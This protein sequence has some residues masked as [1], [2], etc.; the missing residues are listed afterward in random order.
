MNFL[1]LVNKFRNC[2]AFNTKELRETSLVTMNILINDN[3]IIKY[4][5]YRV[6]YQQLEEL[7]VIIEDLKEAGVI[8]DSIS[9]YASPAILVR[10]KNGSLR[11]CIDYRKLNKITRRECF[12]TPNIEEQLNAMVGGSMFCSLDMM[13]GYYQVGIESKCRHLTAF[14]TPG[15]HFQFRRMPFGLTNAPSVFMRLM[16][17]ILQRLNDRRVF[18]Y[19]DDI[20]IVTETASEALEVL[21]KLFTELQQ[22][23]LSLNIQKCSFFVDTV[24]YLGHRIGK[25]GIKPGEQK[26]EAIKHYPEPKNIKEVRQFLGLTGY[27]RRF[28]PSYANI[29]SPLNHLLKKDVNFQW[30]K[31]EKHA[32]EELKHQ[33]VKEPVLTIYD[34]TKDHEVHTDAC[35]TGLAGTLL[36]NSDG[37]QKAVA[38]FSRTTTEQERKYHSYELEALAVVESLERFRYYLLGKKFRIVTDCNSLKLTQEKQNIIPRIARWWL[39]IQEFDF[40]I[41]YRSAAKIVHVDALSRATT[42]EQSPVE[43]V[44]EKVMLVDMEESDWVAVLQLQDADL[45]AIRE[46]LNGTVVNH[47]KVKHYN[48]EYQVKN[49][50]VFKKTEQGLRFVVPHGVRWQIIKTAHNESGHPG[51]DRTIELIRKTYWFPQMRAIIRKYI[52]SCLDCLHNKR[53]KDESRREMFVRDIQPIPFHTIHMDHLGPYPK[54]TA[55]NM[56]LIGVIDAFTKFI[57]LKAV[58]NTRSQYVIRTLE[59]ISQY[60]GLPEQVIT[61]RGT[62]YTSEAFQEFCRENDVVHIKNAVRTPRGNGQIERYFRTVKTAISSMVTRKDGKDWDKSLLAIQW[63]LNNL[64]HRITKVS[65]QKLLLGFE[66][67]SI[68]K[69]KLTF[70]LQHDVSDDEDD[71]P[72]SE[73]RTQVAAEMN[74]S[75]KN[76]AEKFNLSRELPQKYQVGDLVLIKCEH[77]ATGI[78]QKHLPRY[79]GPYII[80]EALTRDRY[81]I[82]DPP[83]YRV[84]NKPFNSVYAAD[85]MRPWCQLQNMQF[86]DEEQ[87][88]SDTSSGSQKK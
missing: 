9:E 81:R 15:G 70:A 28:I 52:E 16:S 19:M 38:Y 13:S 48:K 87:E 71:I 57:V 79:K 29:A 11:M 66:P 23:N 56:Y 42:I 50:R 5:P 76:Q 30:E 86:T 59:D 37:N 25:Y 77:K 78:P 62:A 39:R 61:D 35:A 20:I 65:P 73:L 3:Q 10:K 36:Q 43:G 60:V 12:P 4:K 1:R 51:I 46:V 63:S 45:K 27:F 8:E 31:D 75:R 55:G 74:K 82:T 83:N 21:E 58:R 33:L 32:F 17:I 54:S 49:N 22:A 47:D 41:Q 24:S 6:P 44:A 88:D 68:L 84:T 14:V 26:T 67:K 80:Q 64:S 40:E 2:F 53:Y 69:N 72:L 18:N 85:K 7:K 34:P